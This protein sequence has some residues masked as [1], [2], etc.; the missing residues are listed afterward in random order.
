MGICWCPRPSSIG[1]L[2]GSRGLSPHSPLH[3]HACPISHRN[4]LICW[5]DAHSPH[6]RV[7]GTG[8]GERRFQVQKVITLV[9]YT[10]KKNVGFCWLTRKDIS[11]QNLSITYRTYHGI[12]SPWLATFHRN[13]LHSTYHSI[14]LQLFAAFHINSLLSV[15]YTIPPPLFPASHGISPH[16]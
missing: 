5:I 2:D 15:Y 7:I 8:L 14:T 12:T 4:F 6:H 16:D 13:F 1:R 10:L 9:T 11:S 3:L